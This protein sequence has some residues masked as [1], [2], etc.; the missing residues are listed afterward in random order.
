MEKDLKYLSLLSQNFSTIA[1]TSTEII[2]LQAILN[3]PKGTEHFITDIHGEY[4]AFNH[5]LKNCSGVIREKIENTFGNTISEREKKQLATVIYYPEEKIDLLNEKTE[6]MSQ[7]EWY[8]ITIDRILLILRV[9]SSKYTSSKVR[10]ALPKDFSYIIQELLYERNGEP[11]KKA[12]VSGIIETIISIG[13]AKQ[14]ICAVSGLIQRLTI[15]HLHI[16]GDIYDRGPAPHK[17]MDR[18]IEYHNVDIQWGNHDILWMGAAA[19]QLGCIANVVRICARYGNTDILEDGYG[20]NMLPLATFALEIYK[21]DSCDRFIPKITEKSKEKNIAVLSKMHKAISIIQFKIEGEIV[22]RNYNYKMEDRLLLEKIDYKRGVIE[23][24]GVEYDLSDTYFPTIDKNNPYKLTEEEKEVINHLERS[25]VNSEKLQKHSQFLFSK[26]SVYLKH[27]SNLLYH[28][29][30][31]LDDKGNLREIEFSGKK[32]SGKSLMDA[33]ERFAREG[34]FNTKNIQAHDFL[35]Y[36]W[37]G[38]N[39]PLFGKDKMT[40]FERYFINDKKVHKEIN[41][42]YYEFSDEERVADIILKE[43]GLNPETSHIINGHVPVKVRK[44]EKPIKANGKL[45]IIDG[46]FS[47]AYQSATGIAGY[48]LIANSHGMRLVSHEPFEDTKN[49]I[50]D[51]IDITSTTEIVETRATT[52]RVRDT[53]IGKLLQEQV[54]DLLK[55]LECYRLGIL[56]EKL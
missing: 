53:D 15:D 51:C 28:G 24:N 16:V 34:Y 22:K 8:K 20:I 30:M 25:F 47:K 49:Y 5:V 14:F 32:Y 43:F 36:L 31:P 40:T 13:R 46:G 33:C 4:E 21:D 11:N 3:L 39:S 1:Q 48:T 41:D 27:N 54:K 44:G 45:L 52:I 56:K 17:I 10:K 37:C 6:N 7:T 9:V 18:L 50:Q 42:F 55:L 19:G 26:G 35:W 29:C 12:Y 38:P 2:N 23:L